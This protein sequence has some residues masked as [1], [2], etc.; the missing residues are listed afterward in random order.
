MSED[1]NW[2]LLKKSESFAGR[3]AMMQERRQIQ[4]QAQQPQQVPAQAPAP[5]PAPKND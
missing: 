3:S 4:T 1:E 5:A 2:Q